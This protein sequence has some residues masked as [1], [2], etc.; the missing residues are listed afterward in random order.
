M[1]PPSRRQ[2]HFCRGEES[3]VLALYLLKAALDIGRIVILGEK[4]IGSPGRLLA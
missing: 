1:H 4:V 3:A 2:I